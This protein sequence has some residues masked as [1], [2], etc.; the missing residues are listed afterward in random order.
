MYDARRRDSTPTATSRSRGPRSPR[1]RWPGSPLVGEFHYLHHG[2]DGVPYDDPNAMGNVIAE[3]A[4]AAGIRITLLDTCYLR[5]GADEPLSPA[6]LRF[7]DA[8]ADAWAERVDALA[9]RDRRSG[10]APRSTACGRSIRP[11]PRL[12]A[13]WAAERGAPLHAHVS[14]QPAENEECAGRLRRHADRRAGRAAALS[15]ALHR[16]ARHPSDRRPTSS[17]SAAPARPAA[18]ARPPS[19]TSPT[20]SARPAALRDAGA[21]AGARQRLARGHR[22]LRGGPRDRARRASRPRGARGRHSPAALLAAAGDPRLR[23]PRLARG[24]PHRARRAGRLRHRRR[25]TACASPGPTPSTRWPATVFA[26]TA[27]D[28]T[29]VVVGGRP[30]VRD[31]APRHHRRRRRARAAAIG[32]RDVSTLAIDN[33]GLLVTERPRAGDG[34]LGRVRDAASWLRGRR[35]CSRSSRPARRADER[36]D[37][38]GRCV[39]PGF[40]DSHTH[41]VFAGD[42]AEEF[43]ARM[44]GAALRGRRHPRHRRRDPR[45]QRRRRCARWPPRRRAEALR[46]GITHV[47]IKSGYGLDVDGEARLLRARRRAH[48]RR[49]LPRR[50][51]RAGRV[52]RPPRR[53]RRARVRPRCS[54]PARRTCRWIDVFCEDGA[55][56]ADQSPRRA[57]GRPRRRP[58]PA[59]AR[60]PARPR[61]GRAARRRAGRRL[62]RPLHL[63]RPTPTSTRSP[64]AT[65]SPRFLPATDFSTRQPYPDARRR[66]RRRRHRSRSPRTCNPGSSNTTSMSFCIALAVRDMDMTVEEALRGRDRRRRRAR[67]AAT[68]SAASPRARAPTPSSSTRRRPPTS[69]TGP[70]CRSSPRRSPAAGWRGSRQTGLDRLP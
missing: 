3:A 51:R 8:G 18:S 26:A 63:P 55:F 50:P 64:A 23:A 46:A 65:P 22:P 31:G 42:R 37:A 10:S 56:D 69:S 13:T 27:A 58:R 44:A 68:T 28:V 35:A 49:H 34:P 5:G 43:A 20:A 45:R 29:H 57:R 12:V 62:G 9:R 21:P 70:A 14:E 39:I 25:S 19:A 38:D 32:G 6:Q 53:L 24:R 60:Q 16:G 52:R 2:P 54:P 15:R 67:C 30:I 4:A 61:P 17:C 11:A 40:V 36:I 7:S 33:I 1:W 59:R 66:D 48:R 41:L 47:E